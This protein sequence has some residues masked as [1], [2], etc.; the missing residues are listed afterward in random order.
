MARKTGLYIPGRGRT[1]TDVLR[2]RVPPTAQMIQLEVTCL[3]EGRRIATLEVDEGERITGERILR[4]WWAA[5]PAYG[6]RRWVDG[7]PWLCPRCQCT[8]ALNG[9][10]VYIVGAIRAYTDDDGE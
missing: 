3:G 5:G 6:A 9:T 7:R 2:V 10:P 1:S 8:I 4:G